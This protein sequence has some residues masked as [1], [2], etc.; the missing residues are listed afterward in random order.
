MAHTHMH[1]QQVSAIRRGVPV[2]VSVSGKGVSN[3]GSKQT[4]DE[5]IKYSYTHCI[6]IGR[7]ITT[8]GN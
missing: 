7:H 5:V 2:C 4:R 6:L 8:H 1:T 3:R